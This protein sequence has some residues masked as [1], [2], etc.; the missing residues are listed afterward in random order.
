VRRPQTTVRSS[1]TI[2]PNIRSIGDAFWWAVVTSTTVGYGDISPVTAEGRIIAIMLIGIGAIGA[3]TATVASFFVAQG[4]APDLA[5]V[6][7]R[8]AR[9]EAK[10]DLLLTAGIGPSKSRSDGDDREQLRKA[11]EVARVPSIER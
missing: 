7:Q 9:L 10:V 8:L 4:E 1:K 3:F 5:Q 2:N 11:S 6:E